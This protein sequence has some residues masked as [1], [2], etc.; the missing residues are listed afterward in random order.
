MKLN[1]TKGQYDK[2]SDLSMDIAKGLIVS[3]FVVPTFDH[4]VSL[5][6]STFS[7]VVGLIFVVISLIMEREKEQIQ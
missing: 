2:L 3:S 7:V 6:N 1:L 4:S 5:G